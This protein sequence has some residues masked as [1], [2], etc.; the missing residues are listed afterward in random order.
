MHSAILYIKDQKET[1]LLRIKIFD[2]CLI[3]YTISELKRL[4]IENIYL[5]GD[6]NIDGLIQ[7]DSL[8]DVFEELKNTEG[9]CLLLSPFYPLL[10]KEDYERLL[11]DDD[12]NTVYIDNENN[13]LPLFAI[14]NALLNSYDKLSYDGIV[15]DE[16][17]K[18]RFE[19]K[20]ISYFYE[21]I[22]KRT[23][24]KWINKGV[25][26]LDPNTTM[27]G[28]D[29]R[30][31]QGTY[32]N[33]NTYIGGKSFI[34]YDNVVK[35]NSR[36][37][38]VAIGDGNTIDS[39]LIKDSIIYSN[40]KIGPNAVIENS[41]L[42]EESVVGSYVKLINS[43]VGKKTNINHLSY[44]GDAQ[45]GDSVLIGSGVNTIN[46]DGRSK[47]QTIIKGHSTIGSNVSIIAP[48]TIGEYA[49]VSAG[50]TIDMDVKDG[51]LAIARIF[52]QNKKGY[53]YKYNKED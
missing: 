29:V 43:K 4:D 36:L 20:E 52:Q 41:E 23:I 33:P 21:I 3:S 10:E 14:N 51:D 5:V 25:I 6:K 27:I 1:E 24:N 46:Y 18:K 16:G 9:K 40:C 48:L 28:V 42:Q 47:H 32:I 19:I 17:K 13:I 2:K 11:I 8:E 38:N 22:K 37:F 7:R 44:I 26:I 34:G 31:G 39:S 53:G 45:I 15:I 35:E 30:I 12:N 50:S 49:T